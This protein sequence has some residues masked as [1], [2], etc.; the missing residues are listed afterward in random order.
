ML[1]ELQACRLK[2]L[3]NWK[4][5]ILK[6]SSEAADIIYNGCN[7]NKDTYIGANGFADI[8]IEMKLCAWAQSFLLIGR[9]NGE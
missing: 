7:K 8:G 5:D 6:K 2:R 1:P 9:S 4:G 3:R